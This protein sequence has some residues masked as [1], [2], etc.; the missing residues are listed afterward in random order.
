MP[1]KFLFLNDF[2]SNSLSSG[3]D[4]G[5]VHP[6]VRVYQRFFFHIDDDGV[7]LLLHLLL[8]DG[9]NTANTNIRFIGPDPS[10]Y[11]PVV[12]YQQG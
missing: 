2:H 3:E 10:E 8:N 5:I 11:L 4:R 1:S 7:N 6:D 9:A 12:F